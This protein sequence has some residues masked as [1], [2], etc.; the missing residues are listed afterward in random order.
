MERQIVSANLGENY[1]RLLNRRIWTAGI[2]TSLFLAAG[3]TFLLG[4]FSSHWQETALFL[5]AFTVV[6]NVVIITTAKTVL[7][8]LTLIID[9][10]FPISQARKATPVI[11]LTQAE[12]AIL[13]HIFTTKNSQPIAKTEHSISID[14]L[15]RVDFGVISFDPDLNLNY[16]NQFARK[17]FDLNNK[18]LLD[19]ADQIDLKTWIMQSQAERLN[20]QH[21]WTNLTFTDPETK[22][23][24][25]FNLTA[26]FQ[27]A[28]RNETVIL[29]TATTEPSKQQQ[30]FDFIAYAAHE[31]RGPITIIRGYLDIL[32]ADFPSK[33]STGQL[34]MD[35]LTVA[36][37]RLSS[38]INNILNVAKFDQKSFKLSLKPTRPAAIIDEIYDDI[39]LRASTNQKK[40]SIEIQP[41]LPEINLDR[42][43]LTQAITNLVDNAIKYSQPDDTIKIK[44]FKQATDIIFQVIDNGIGMPSSTVHNLFKRFYRSQRTENRIGGTGIGLFITKAIVDAHHG[45]ITVLSEPDKGSSFTISLPIEQGLSQT[46]SNFIRNHG[47]LRK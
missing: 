42:T 15:D 7:K 18:L 45:T 24:S 16:A 4:K 2:L 29:I 11:P 31:L 6:Y 25:W 1:L 35:R 33:S 23:L 5:I 36:G 34:I 46:S 28:D 13:K 21:S 38:Y 3:T 22:N 14:A 12:N 9:A 41:D 47:L 30:D 27:K 43:S 26:K 8:R 39:Y 17:L 32:Q 10:L 19:F 44:V 40:L 37:N 20:N